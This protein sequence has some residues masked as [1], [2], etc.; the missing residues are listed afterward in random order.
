MTQAKYTLFYWPMAFRGCFVSYQFAYKNE[1]LTLAGTWESIAAMNA[2]QPEEQHIPCTG[3]PI[4]LE[5][6]TGHYLSQTP[7]IIPYI[8]GI[9]GLAPSDLYAAALCMKIQMDC[10]DVLMEICRHNGSQ[11]WSREEWIHFR[12]QRLPR[13][14]R[15]FEESI[16]RGF[17]GKSEVSFADISVF[18]LFG[19]MVRCLPELENDLRQHAPNVHQ[20]C[21]TLSE[22]PSLAKA[23]AFDE[24][25]GG[26]T[27]C[28]G[29]IEKS[30]R[31]MLD[32]DNRG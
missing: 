2:Q 14:M 21:Q 27:Y 28:G 18:A 12:T 15:V 19:N 22:S 4:L 23:V 16:K 32:A 24:Q 13:W 31:E 8:A 1:P 7:A 26:K 25:R 30:I 10:N 3:P 5:H 20:L 11:M 6:E 9:L 17:I 29:Q